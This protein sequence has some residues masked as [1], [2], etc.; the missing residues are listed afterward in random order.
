MS[1]DFNLQEN[2]WLTKLYKLNKKWANYFMKNTFFID[3]QS[4]Q[5]SESLK[6]TRYYTIEKKDQELECLPG[7]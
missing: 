7:G 3:M 6:D 4:T 1:R 2:K 5:I